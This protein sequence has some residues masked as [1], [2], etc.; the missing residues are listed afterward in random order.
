VIV[1]S[2]LMTASAVAMRAAARHAQF[3]WH[4]RHLDRRD[5]VRPHRSAFR[6]RRPALT[7]LLMLG[8]FVRGNP[9]S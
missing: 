1:L 3:S 4:S 5:A 7:V 6:C 9:W 2:I 8:C